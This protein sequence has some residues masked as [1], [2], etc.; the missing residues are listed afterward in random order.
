[1]PTRRTLMRAALGSALVTAGCSASHTK[2]TPKAMDKVTHITGFGAGGSEAFSW[3]AQAKGFFSEV[4]IDVTI[5]PGAAGDQNLANVQSGNAQFTEI[6]YAGALI[7]GG[8]AG[9]FDA[10][11]CVAAIHW[12]TQIAWI[13]LANNGIT[14]ATDLA[15]KTVAEQAGSVH[16]TL[17]P[18]YAKQAGFDPATV[19]WAEGTAQTLPSMLGTKNVDAIGQYVVSAPTIKGAV[20]RDVVVLPYGQYLTD[21]YGSVLVTSNDLLTK[22]P[23]LV[24]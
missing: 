20:K 24:H 10:F 17:F 1:M 23:D 16:K 8:Q 4:N 9:K 6:D 3:V 14:T 11:R 18:I 5:K 2:N 12:Q 22:N 7:R 21:L 15:H 19:N 13:A